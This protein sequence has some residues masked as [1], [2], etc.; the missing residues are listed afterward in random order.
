[1]SF[2][3]FDIGYQYE[4]S[5]SAINYGFQHPIEFVENLEIRGGVIACYALIRNNLNDSAIYSL[6]DALLNCRGSTI[7]SGHLILSHVV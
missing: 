7:C 3:G 1:M 4:I 2:A 6:N 5:K